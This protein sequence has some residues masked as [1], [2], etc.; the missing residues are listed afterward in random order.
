MGGKFISL[1]HYQSHLY[2]YLGVSICDIGPI[3]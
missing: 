1:P 2:T 3:I